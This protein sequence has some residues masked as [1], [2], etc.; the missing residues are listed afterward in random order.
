MSDM[1]T[2]SVSARIGESD[3]VRLDV[4]ASTEHLR[5]VRLLVSSVATAHG[6]DLEDLEDLRLA[7]GEVCAHAISAAG[8]HDRM[9]VS[10]AVSPGVDDAALLTVRASV[11]SAIDPGS[12]DELSSMV[13]EAA[14]DRHGVDVDAVSV[15]AWF[16]RTVRSVRSTELRVD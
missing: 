14:T 15:S 7:A 5:L 12:L 11:D 3:I 10:A 6:A 4:P 1:D 16:S 2:S 13:L 8:A 9:S